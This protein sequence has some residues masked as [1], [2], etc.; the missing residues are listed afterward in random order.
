MNKKLKYMYHKCPICKK[1][2]VV[3]NVN[4]CD[5]KPGTCRQCIKDIMGKMFPEPSKQMETLTPKRD[6]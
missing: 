5:C 6:K 1:I 4:F 2:K 3:S